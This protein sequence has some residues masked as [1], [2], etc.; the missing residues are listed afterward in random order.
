MRQRVFDACHARRHLVY[1]ARPRCCRLPVAAQGQYV[2]KPVAEKKLKQ[3]PPGPLYWRVE[4]FPTFAQAQV[5]AGWKPDLVRYDETP[6][7]A[8]EVA[9]KAWLFTLGSKRWLNSGRHQGHRDRTSTSDHGPRIPFEGQPWQWTAR[10]QDPR[11]HPS[12][13]RSLLCGRGTVGPKD[14]ARR[15]PRGRGARDER[16]SRGHGNGGIQ[17]RFDRVDGLDHVRGRREPAVLGARQI[18]LTADDRFSRVGRA[19]RSCLCRDQS[20]IGAHIMSAPGA[21]FLDAHSRPRSATITKRSAPA[22]PG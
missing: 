14:A 10:R 15:Q 2:V 1:S 22:R 16:A 12:R 18:A 3:L 21:V 11:T 9:G 7:L 13:L 19:K 8:A 6:A 17:Q 20:Y 5:A 4:K